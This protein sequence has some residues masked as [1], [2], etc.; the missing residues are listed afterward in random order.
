[1]LRSTV[2]LTGVAG[3][4]YYSTLHWGGTTDGE[5]QAAADAHGHFWNQLQARLRSTM[6][7]TVAEEVAL[8][9]VA[10]GQILELFPVTGGS[11][12]FSDTGEPL[13]PSNQALLRLRTGIYVAGREL[14]GRLNV[15]GCMEDDSS[16]G[17]PSGSL[18]T[19]V[20]A[21]WTF[22]MT[23]SGGAAGGPVVYSDTHHVSAPVSFVSMWNQ[24]AVLRSRRD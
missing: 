2:L 15:P 23:T 3:A 5:A 6:T 7:A 9:D 19:A 16:G 22:A 14:R 4:P 13:P 11:V 12:A 21:A 1:M 24:W 10:T 8:V 17:V 18:I 20:E